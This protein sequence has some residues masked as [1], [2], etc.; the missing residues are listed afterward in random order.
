MYMP[1]HII[2]LVTVLNES[3]VGVVIWRPVISED[4]N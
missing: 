3:S 1:L 4:L 2:S